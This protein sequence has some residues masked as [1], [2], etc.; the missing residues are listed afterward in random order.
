M[1]GMIAKI[2]VGPLR[3]EAKGEKNTSASVKCM[4]VKV[5]KGALAGY[6]P[7]IADFPDV[8]LDSAKMD[9]S[10]DWPFPQLFYT[11]T[12]LYLGTREGMHSL[13][14]VGNTWT[15]TRISSGFAGELIWPWTL[16][17]CPMFPVFASGNCLV[18][19]DGIDSAWVTW[20]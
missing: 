15:A 7:S 9:L 14:L 1:R 12:G 2:G 11:D 20:Y 10:K 19:Y 16:A 6:T 18:Y 8:Y 3:Q 17:D 4:N 5:Y 13:A